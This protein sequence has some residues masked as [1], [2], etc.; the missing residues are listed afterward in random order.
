M[1]LGDRVDSPDA[2]KLPLG[3]AVSLLKG[4][5]GV[6]DLSLPLSGDLY[7]PSVG[8]GQIIRTAIVGLI[9]NVA[10][11]PFSLLSGL[12]G[13]DADISKVEFAAGSSSVD[14]EM[15]KVLGLLSEALE[16]R[17]ELSVVLVPSVSE[18]DLILL[19]SRQL[20]EELLA[21]SEKK[22]DATF[23]KYLKRAYKAY[24]KEHDP[25]PYVIPEEQSDEAE[26]AFMKSVLLTE[27]IPSGATAQELLKQR[28]EA[29]RKQ[30]VE[31]HLV[32]AERVV[33]GES[34]LS[35]DRPMVSFELE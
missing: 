24:A 27:L 34:D 17:P 29:V 4:P 23:E 15:A 21:E 20:R 30:L 32:A 25:L 2:I 26:I 19:A 18:D 11:A 8:L 22:D 5:D 7:D 28:A 12:V 33:L 13:A 1:E 35:K 9:T 6:M 31:V 16:K 10:S 14:P 3:L